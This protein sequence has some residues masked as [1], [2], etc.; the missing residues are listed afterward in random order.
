MPEFLL[1]L[2]QSFSHTFY[3]FILSNLKQQLKSTS[4]EIGKLKEAESQSKSASQSQEKQS[5]DHIEQLKSEISKQ[6]EVV[7][8]LN[9]QG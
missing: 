8:K 3:H 7:A 1:C 9:D 2:S 4:E 6:L 5:N